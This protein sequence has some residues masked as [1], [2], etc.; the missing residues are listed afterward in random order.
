[1]EIEPV[2]RAD[3]MRFLFDWQ[4]VAPGSQV[5][6]AE[7][8]AGVLAQLEGFQAAAGAWESEI[9]PSRVRDYGI[10]WLDDLCR[11][12]RL[13]WCRLAGR[14]RS[15]GGP[16]RSTPIVL[17]PRKALATWRNCLEAVPA[18]EPSPRAE[19]VRRALAEHGALFFDELMDEAR[20]LRSE[21][22][23]ALGELVAL[24]LVH[25]DSFAGLRSLLLPAARRG[26]SAPRARAALAS[27]QDAGR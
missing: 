17:L 5:R 9:L 25:A 14:T 21:L 7:A 6:G 3:F 16:L 12:G 26:R 10:N 8:L 11:A 19:R 22:E 4:R 15:G 18:A 27:L 24:G 23:D 1:R 2:E 13:I 20:L